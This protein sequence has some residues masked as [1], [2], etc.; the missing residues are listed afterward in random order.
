MKQGRSTRRAARRHRS[1]L[2]LFLGGLLIVGAVLIWSLIPDQIAQAPGNQT[3]SSTADIPRIE[4]N[5]AKAAFDE[6]TAVFLDVRSEVEYA[7]SH[8]PG[9]VSIPLDQLEARVSELN[10]GDWYITYCT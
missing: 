3:Y 8:I 2:L 6:R 7:Q 4:L 1:I 10:P 9:A 5:D